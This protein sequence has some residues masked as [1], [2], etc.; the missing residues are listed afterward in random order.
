MDGDGQL[1]VLDPDA[2]RVVRLTPDGAVDLV[3]G[4]EGGGPGEFRRPARVAAA[5]TGAFAVVDVARDRLIRFAADGMLLDETPIRDSSI[6]LTASGYIA[7]RY[8]F[9]GSTFFSDLVRIAGG[10][11]VHLAA[12]PPV[13]QVRYRL[14]DRCG[15]SPWFINRPF[16]APEVT[17]HAAGGFAVYAQGSGY[18]LEV[19]PRDRDGA[20]VRQVRRDLSPL[21]TTHA[22]ALAAAAEEPVQAMRGGAECEYPAED[23]VG[24]RGF[25]P[26][27]RRVV[28]ITLSP[29]GDLWVERNGEE[30]PATR[31]DVFDAEGVYVGTLPA[32][33]PLPLHFLPD[34]RALLVERDE[35][36]V[37][38]MVVASI[39][40]R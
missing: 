17:W 6:A 40:R 10:G 16:F 39:R 9:A 13:P 15:P 7:H 11:T 8:H 32:E 35:M 25:H 30:V 37:Q 38:R 34:G 28:E 26:R 18:V 22:R 4:R 33:T 27:I 21:Q 23:I 31:I 24:A 2:H 19:V 20:M 5:A 12:S 1:L 36:D 29:R 14:S 3:V